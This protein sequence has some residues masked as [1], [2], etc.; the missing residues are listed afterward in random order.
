MK[1]IKILF[2]MCLFTTL[3]HA[4][5]PEKVYSI[6]KDLH[7]KSWYEEQLR[8]WK[9]ETEKNPKNA[10]AWYYYFSASRALRNLAYGD[11]DAVQKHQALC[12]EIAK[13]MLE[14]VPNTFEANHI[15]WWNGQRTE[16]D[17]AY[18]KKAYEINPNDSRTYTD[19]MVHYEIIQEQEQLAQFAR[20]TFT[21]N[22]MASAVLNWAYNIL[23][24]VDDHSIVFTAG[25]NDTFSAWTVQGAKN[26]RK[27]VQIINTSLILLDDYRNKLFEKLGIPALPI[28][29]LD[30][31]SEE[32]YTKAYKS[33]FD[34]IFKNYKKGSVYISATA[35]QQF[36]NWSDS[37]YLTGLAYKYAAESFDNVS[38]IKRNY[39]KRYLL[40]HLKEV[41]S[42]NVANDVANRLDAVYLASMIKLYNH[43]VESESTE[44]QVA[45]LQL[46][47]SISERTGQQTEVAELLES[48]NKVSRMYQTTLLN[49]K[50]IE[51]NMAKLNGKTFIGKY[52]VS[53]AEFNQFLSNLLRS[54]QDDFYKLNAYDSSQWVKKFSYSFND[55]MVVNYHWHP[56]YSNYP[57][58]N[59]S[60]EA[61]VNY[62]NW[63]TTQYNSQRKRTY[64]QVLFRLPT[65]EEWKSAATSGNPK[66][67]SCF[68]NGSVTNEKK[69]Y[70]ANLKVSEGDY[71]SDGSFLTTSVDSYV[72]N[73]FGLFNTIGNAA[74]MTSKKGVALGG[75]WYHT[76][77][78]ST[79]NKTQN[80]SGADPGIG[81]RI[82]M[83]VIQE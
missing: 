63:L 56:A 70:L 58:V 16:A 19:L 8:L 67:N 39:E 54:R 6:I 1:T 52:E 53:N 71:Y 24:E 25:D 27:D 18:L 12:D 55:P 59:I 49:T 48:N 17:I 51:K 65:E 29:M 9:L 10:E 64:T 66:N 69:C 21:A 76:F 28:K 83:E 60:Y 45:L 2:I 30:Q 23:A 31:T 41:F 4:Q 38:I 61:A 72:A 62:C 15:Q 78:E 33:L 75:S 57:V 82:I 37:L 74:E 13:K 36:D 42:F 47:V 73:K 43:Y 44:K 5:K 50:E 11:N 3:A 46:I 68:E 26:F 77:E 35:I 7:E 20:K 32:N 80:Y 14:V 40:D 81:F 34:H 22:E 79:F